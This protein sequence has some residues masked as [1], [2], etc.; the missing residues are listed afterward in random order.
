MFRDKRP[1]QWLRLAGPPPHTRSIH[2]RVRLEWTHHQERRS[3]EALL[4][5]D[6]GTTGAVLI[7]DW[8]NVTTLRQVA[9]I[10]ITLAQM[11]Y[12]EVTRGGMVSYS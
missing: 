11:V 4:L 10:T 2:V 9:T 6:S 7:N 1:Q 3:S 5:L 12:L 8:V